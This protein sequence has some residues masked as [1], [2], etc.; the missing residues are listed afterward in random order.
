[1][2]GNGIREGML[3]TNAYFKNDGSFE[4]VIADRETRKAKERMSQE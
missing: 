2:S 4:D 1:M 3:A